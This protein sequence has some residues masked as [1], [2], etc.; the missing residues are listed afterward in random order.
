MTRFR[1]PTDAGRAAMAAIAVY[2]M[3]ELGAALLGYV[4]P[5]EPLRL[6]LGGVTLR[7]P[8]ALEA[9]ASP[10]GITYAAASL[11]FFL[12][13]VLFCRWIYVTHANSAVLAGGLSMGP[14]AAVGWFFVPLADLLKPFAA[15]EESWAASHR[16][17]GIEPERRPRPIYGFW[18]TWAL[19]TY[20]F[21]GGREAWLLDSILTVAMSLY[22]M[23]LI[24]RLSAVQTRAVRILA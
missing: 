21:H 12:A 1:D 24:G 4:L 13:L 10:V 18:W 20:V 9:L 8:V 16:A 2:A 17:A 15:L 22:L 19:V 11:A 7:G 6:R 3:L 23:Q 5:T 14:G